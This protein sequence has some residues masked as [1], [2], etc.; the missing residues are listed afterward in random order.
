[1]RLFTAYIQAFF[2]FIG[3]CF[4][5]LVFYD[6]LS[7][8]FNIIVGALVLVIGFL[9]SRFV[10]KMVKH[11]GLISTMS[12]NNSSYGL[13]ELEPVEGSEVVKL[14]PNELYKQ[15]QD[16]KLNFIRGTV[17]I[18]GDH[19]GQFL[20][21]IHEIDA[22]NY[23]MHRKILVIRFKSLCS[24]KVSNPKRVFC[25]DS[26][27]KIVKAKE[28]VWQTVDKSGAV[29]Q[30][31]YICSGGQIKTTSNTKWKPHEFDLGIGMPAVY[32]QG[33]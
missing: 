27:L 19:Q 15:F 1:M 29:K 20:N 17:C 11:R 28:V 30:Y 31:H 26:Y 24:L 4:I 3:A 22:I 9:G 6:E 32:L 14:E 10:F 16:S 5:A 18:W 25:A 7:Q 8:P 2:A 21:Q 13:D 12:G 23:D 33:K